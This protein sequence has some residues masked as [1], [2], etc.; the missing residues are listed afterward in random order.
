M[1]DPLGRIRIDLVANTAEFAKELNKAGKALEEAER[2]AK[3][4]GE[5]L[6]KSLE[7]VE[8]RMKRFGAD[9]TKWITLPMVG[10]AAVSIRAADSTGSFSRSIRELGRQ[11]SQ[12]LAPLG[13]ALIEAFERMRPS[14]ERVIQV[15]G[16]MATKFSELSPQTQNMIITLAAIAAATGPVI[17]GLAA[18]V[19]VVKNLTT[20]MKAMMVVAAAAKRHPLV[21]A[22]SAAAAVGGTA[23]IADLIAKAEA[24]EVRSLEIP[25]DV[26]TFD[27]TSFDRAIALRR[28]IRPLEELSSRLADLRVLAADYPGIL[29]PD[30][31]EDLARKYEREL[32]PAFAA[33]EAEM[34]KMQSRVDAITRATLGQEGRIRQ[35]IEEVRALMMLRILPADIGHERLRQLHDEL[36]RLAT[37]GQETFGDRL[38]HAIKGFA[39]GAADAF[40]DM[41]VDGTASFDELAKSWAKTL[42]GMAAQFWVLQ[43]IFDALGTTFGGLFGGVKQPVGDPN[44]IGPRYPAAHGMVKFATGGASAGVVKRPTA[45]PLATGMIG[46][47]GKPEAYFPLVQRGGDL[48]IRGAT[49]PVIV[50]VIDQRS[51]GEAVQVRESTGPNGERQ[52]DVIVREAMRRIIGSGGMDR[53]FGQAY[54]LRRR[55]RN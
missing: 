38:S 22:L 48:A 9:L 39:S 49:P 3:K 20:A 5:E 45:F 34:A 27:T 23:L 6:A 29:S 43:P 19:M 31:V 13:E 35:D 46:E 55:G 8:K 7:R 51:G 16:L 12:S 37:L 47:A 32:N 25:E 21:L 18:T 33:A 26:R 30:V 52:I 24:A 15:L 36:Q 14:I 50:N 11:A 4:F 41:V 17:L 40:A 42:I 1:S 53:L 2:K 44:F 28:S 54:G 10:I